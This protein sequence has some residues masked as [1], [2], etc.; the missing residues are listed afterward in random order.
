MPK[1]TYR[2]VNGLKV[3]NPETGKHLKAGGE[4]VEDSGY[5]R[6]QQRAK[7]VERVNDDGRAKKDAGKKA[8][9]GAAAAADADAAAAGGQK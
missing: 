6:R 9:K 8:Q 5:W 1:V 2:P 7:A 4:L 3:P